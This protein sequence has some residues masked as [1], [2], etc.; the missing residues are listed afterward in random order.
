MQGDQAGEVLE[1]PLL[2]VVDPVAVQVQDLQLHQVPKPGVGNV[3]EEIPPQVEHFQAPQAVKGVFWKLTDQVVVQVQVLHLPAALKSS[4]VDDIYPVVLQVQVFQLDQALQG[5]VGYR[6]DPVSLQ[7][8]V[9]QVLHAPD[10]TRDPAEV[11]LEAEELLQGGQLDEDP[12]R[13]VEEVAVR[14]VQLDQPP[15]GSESPRVEV[16]D[17][18]VVGHLQLHQAGQ[19]LESPRGDEGDV[20]V[21]EGQR[22]EGRQRP[23]GPLGEEL[24]AV[25]IQVDGGGFAREL[26]GDLPQPGTVTEDGAAPLLGAHAAGRAGPHAGPH[27]VGTGHPE[28]HCQRE[29]R[30]PRGGVGGEKGDTSLVN[31]LGVREDCAVPASLPARLIVTRH[32]RVH[33]DQEALVSNS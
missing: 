1:S 9:G 10:G 24:D 18:L 15:E 26:A 25:F 32:S 11:V 28:D 4:L 13:D 23:E 30:R 27:R 33:A 14:Q 16:A 29:A 22:L 5:V 19:P 2:D 21:V 3:P 6:L 7:V 20:V 8:D 12:V 31:V 17:V